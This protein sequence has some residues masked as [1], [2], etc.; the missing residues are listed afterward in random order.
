MPRPAKRGSAA[1]ITL[2]FRVTQ[3]EADLID[4]SRGFQSLSDFI[5]DC[6]MT[7]IR[8]MDQPIREVP[9]IN[10]DERLMEPTAHRHKR[11]KLAGETVIKGVPHRT[12]HCAEPGCL[13]I[14]GDKP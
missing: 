4:T 10:P 6:V 5:R 7:R 13:T 11:G 8:L 9:P 14:L 1:T 12:Y 2:Q 3:P